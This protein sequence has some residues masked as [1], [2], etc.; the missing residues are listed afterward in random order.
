MLTNTLT[1]WLAVAAVVLIVLITYKLIRLGTDRIHQLKHANLNTPLSR[2]RESNTA[3]QMILRGSG[4]VSGGSIGRRYELKCVDDPLGH[5]RDPEIPQLVEDYRKL[6]SGELLDPTA[7]HAPSEA[8][9][10][11]VNPDYIQYL[12][13]QKRAL[14]RAGK[15]AT[16]FEGEYKRVSTVQKEEDVSRDFRL[17]IHKMGMPTELTYV[18]CSEERIESYAPSDWSALIRAMKRFKGKFDLPS[19]HSYLVNV[20]RKETLLDE[21]RLEQYELLLGFDVPEK[22]C[23]AL[24]QAE[25]DEGQFERIIRLIE[26][27]DYH[28]EDAIREVIVSDFTDAKLAQKRAEY[29]RMTHS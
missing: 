13:S 12:K 4:E 11:S 21:D 5:E 10:G 14:K 18:A 15:D 8:R 9:E 25:I 16:W 17:E 7:S 28:Y 24:V 20:T 2:F 6:L 3:D 1:L 27:R 23:A 26:E 22:V 29:H 19:I